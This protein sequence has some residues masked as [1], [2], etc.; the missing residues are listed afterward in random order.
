M[1]V[2]RPIEKNRKWAH[3][4]PQSKPVSKISSQIKISKDEENF[5]TFGGPKFGTQELKYL[6]EEP[7]ITDPYET[8]VLS[9][10][11]AVKERLLR[12]LRLGIATRFDID[13]QSLTSLK[14]LPE[15]GAISILVQFMLS[16]PGE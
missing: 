4:D 14:E 12:I 10:P 11:V 2:A 1:E 9:L 3:D 7:V 13:I 5:N 6:A 8:A 15:S 16:G